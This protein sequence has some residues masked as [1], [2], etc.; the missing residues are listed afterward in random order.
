MK[1]FL[2]AAAIVLTTRAEA[3][4][5]A[6]PTGRESAFPA[7]TVSVSGT[8]HVRLTPDRFSFT[9]GVQTVAPTVDD[10]VRE[11]NQRVAAVVAA[12][13]K[14][15]ATPAEIR[16][17]NFSIYPQQD[18]S[19]NAEGKLPRILGYQVNNTVTVTRN[20]V[21]AASKLLQAA[22]SAGV[23]TASGLQFEVSDPARGRDDGLAAAFADAR[24]KASVLA[25]SA[26]RTLGRTLTISE[27]GATPPP[28]PYPRAMA[29]KAD[30]G[31]AESVT[32]EP[33]TQELT[34]SVA[35]V[36]ELR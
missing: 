12:L 29:M 7:E 23:N 18:Y 35:V 22:V 27:G 8:G 21:G 3:Q 11:N 25:R 9:A 6:S 2:V 4:T 19:Q 17:S 36:F 26:G 10:A 16:T 28:P 20:D 31:A 13:K 32:V 5:A 34:F 24:A 14:A 30:Q 1:R 15:G 33:G